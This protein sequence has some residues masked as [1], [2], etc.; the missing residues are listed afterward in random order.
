MIVM[1][2]RAMPDSPLGGRMPSILKEK[3]PG[4]TWRNKRR[5]EDSLTGPLM[6]A[7]MWTYHR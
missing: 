5:Q 2:S 3:T 7:N 6:L 4:G 1:S